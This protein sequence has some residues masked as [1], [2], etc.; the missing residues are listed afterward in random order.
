MHPKHVR[1]FVL[2]G[3]LLLV[4][5]C[6]PKLETGYTPRPLNSSEADRRAYYAQPFTP[7]SHP[8]KDSGGGPSFEGL[9]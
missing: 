2:A 8:P 5:A 6:E 9:H 4:T 7:E 3:C 1:F